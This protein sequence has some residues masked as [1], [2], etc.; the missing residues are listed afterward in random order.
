MFDTTIGGIRCKISLLFPAVLLFL[1]MLDR[2]GLAAFGFSAALLHESGHAA[3]LWMIGEKPRMLA[4]S[5]YGMRLELEPRG[6][7]LWKELLLYL[8][9]PIVNGLC[10]VG[11]HILGMPPLCGWLHALLAVF[12]LLPILPLD[13]GQVLYA[14]LC[15]LVSLENA[16]AFMKIVFVMLLVPLAAL[17]AALLWYTG[18]FTLLVTALYVG[19][20]GLFCKGN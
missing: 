4:V 2:T 19:M 3:V 18:N 20:I 17:G 15:R 7:P 13:G 1:L 12:N 11:M 8:G 5:F 10:A 16:A 14:L 6:R 9:G